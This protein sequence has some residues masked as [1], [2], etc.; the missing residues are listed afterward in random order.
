MTLMFQNGLAALILAL[1]DDLQL[2]QIIKRIA[3]FDK[4]ECHLTP[5]KRVKALIINI[6][7]CR[8]AIC[9]EQLSWCFEL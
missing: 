2:G 8:E 4:S 7:S 9:R 1:F 5:G 6:Y 3:R